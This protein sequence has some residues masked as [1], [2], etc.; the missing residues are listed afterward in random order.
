VRDWRIG[1]ETEGHSGSLRRG[2]FATFV[3][4]FL[5]LVV[6]AMIAVVIMLMAVMV[7]VM[8]VDVNSMTMVSVPMK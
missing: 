1:G 7:I 5:V 4:V 2:V 8:I 6:V 3:V